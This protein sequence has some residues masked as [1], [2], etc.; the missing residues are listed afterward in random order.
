MASIRLWQDRLCPHLEQL[1]INYILW[2]LEHNFCIG[3]D[4]WIQLRR[5]RWD[6]LSA[7]ENLE[8]VDC[9]LGE[10]RDWENP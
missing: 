2:G 3:F 10:E 7:V 5:T 1:F 9:Y 8:V 4:Y 6:M